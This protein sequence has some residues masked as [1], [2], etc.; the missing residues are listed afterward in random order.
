MPRSWGRSLAMKLRRGSLHL[1]RLE[2]RLTLSHSSALIA[3]ETGTLGP[4][5]YQ[6]FAPS[7]ALQAAS[8][9]RDP[10]TLGPMEWH[11][12]QFQQLDVTSTEVQQ[13][14]A[15]PLLT[16]GENG[17]PLKITILGADAPQFSL[18]SHPISL[19][20]S[21]VDATQLVSIPRIDGRVVS[22]GW[23]VADLGSRADWDL[24]SA[25]ILF[26]R[27]TAAGSELAQARHELANASS[28]ELDGGASAEADTGLQDRAVANSS[29]ANVSIAGLPL[30]AI[31]PGAAAATQAAS[32][33][34][35]V[36]P[37]LSLPLATAAG[38]IGTGVAPAIGALIHPGVISSHD[39]GATAADETGDEAQWTQ[40]SEFAAPF[41]AY[42]PMNPV[43]Y[44]FSQAWTVAS[45][46]GESL[47]AWAG[48]DNASRDRV[49][50]LASVALNNAALDEAIEN[51][52][53]DAEQLG[54]GM[55]SWL[56]EVE[57]PTGSYA[58]SA[59]AAAGLG[60]A[61]ALRA[62]GKKVREEE[63]EAVSSTWLLTHVQCTT[64]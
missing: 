18:Q 43:R 61:F 1:E 22:V 63:A 44:V 28:A 48:G 23:F 24:D 51:L 11:T 31:L 14:S 39:A 36:A 30:S 60:A 4:L 58:A 47:G 2:Q 54:G 38:A 21:G 62:R 10:S 8:I 42:L 64:V 45:N 55:I 41:D 29:Q 46:A 57:L 34:M 53:D 19:I 35:A 12:V 5:P 52:I 3:L 40:R 6:P 27:S 17:S 15:M 16:R 20:S 56:E 32:M 50:M 59:V 25:Y 13:F 49:G 33:T 9:S 26:D 7:A 37:H